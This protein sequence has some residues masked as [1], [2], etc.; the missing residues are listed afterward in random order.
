MRVS[1]N[2]FRLLLAATLAFG[3][4]ISAAPPAAAP[5]PEPRPAMWLLSDADTKIYMLGT[6]HILPPGFK[7]RSAALDKVV[8]EADELVVETYMEPGTEE[9]LFAR[10][11]ILKEPEP[12]LGRVP[13]DKRARLAAAIKESEL[14]EEAFDMIPTWLGAVVLGIEDLLGSLGVDEVDDAPGVEDIL[15]EDFRKAKKPI[16]SV[17]DFMTVLTAL[18]DLPEEVQVQMLMESIAAET[19]PTKEDADEEHKLWVTGEVE[20]LMLDTF[21]DMPPAMLDVLVTRR[22]AAWTEWLQKRLEQPGTVLF[23]V[24]TGHLAG[25]QSV[26]NMLAKKG[27]TARRIH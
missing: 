7:W 11:M 15:E 18:N 12:I 3:A 17:E 24:G 27:L 1:F 22:N 6:V 14:P 19:K 10:A 4:P 25:P 9:A 23:A 16:R 20:A 21:A 8:A 13:A 2:K 5:A 26:Q